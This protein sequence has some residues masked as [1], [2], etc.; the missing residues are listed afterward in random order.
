MYADIDNNYRQ[1]GIMYSESYA[2][3]GSREL[4]YIAYNMHWESCSLAL[5]KIEGDNGFKVAAMTYST[6]GS[7]CIDSEARK[8]TIPP[9][10][11][12][13]LTGEYQERKKPSDVA[14]VG[15]QAKDENVKI[16]CPKVKM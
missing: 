14:A 8:V 15:K 6:P 1:I 3:K 12:A 5:P 2:D 7:V 9:R 11:M 4:I 16:E 10:S 13:V